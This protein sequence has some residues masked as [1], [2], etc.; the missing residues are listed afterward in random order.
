MH[1]GAFS[2]VYDSGGKAV[3][4]SVSTEW[5]FVGMPAKPALISDPADRTSRSTGRFNM[6]ICPAKASERGGLF[7]LVWRVQKEIS[8][9]YFFS[10]C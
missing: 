5:V 6:E 2:L 7:P 4:A 3:A 8:A 10:S 1:D 9:G